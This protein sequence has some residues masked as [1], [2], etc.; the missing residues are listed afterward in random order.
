MTVKGCYWSM[1]AL[2]NLGNDSML[3]IRDLRIDPASLDRKMLLVDVMT[4]YEYKEGKRTETVT[5]YRYVVCPAEHRL[6]KLR[7][8]RQRSFANYSGQYRRCRTNPQGCPW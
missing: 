7:Q 2:L 6:E 1:A 8:S 5:G 3:N 4:A